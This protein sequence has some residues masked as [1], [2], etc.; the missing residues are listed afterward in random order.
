[1]FGK[2]QIGIEESSGGPADGRADQV[3]HLDQAVSDRFQ[4]FVIGLPQSA[5]PH[6][7]CFSASADCQLAHLTRVAVGTGSM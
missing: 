3:S 7:P 5:P 4:L 2:L 6:V 1:M